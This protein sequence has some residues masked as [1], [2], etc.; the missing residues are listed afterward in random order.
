MRIIVVFIFLLFFSISSNAKSWEYD[1]RDALIEK[2][3][4]S[5]NKIHSLDMRIID[6]YINKIS[7]HAKQ[8]PP[9]FSSKEEQVEVIDKLQKLLSLLEIISESQHSN[10][11]FLVRAAFS[12]SMGHNVNLKGAAEKSK[13]YFE[14][15]LN[16]KPDDPVVNYQYGMFL[17]GTKKYHYDSIPFLEKALK[18]GYEGARYTLGLLYYQQ[19]NNEKGI[20]M[21][22]KY[23]SD[24]PDNDHAKKV[25][26]SI[27]TG[28]LRFESK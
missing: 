16:I 2:D 6:Y 11:E 12:N 20:I 19:G 21:L 25:I 14:L 13:I 7:R 18:L 23:S 4:G 28:K 15:L 17:L 22:K 1:L 9:R 8:Y 24:N 26:D 3:D 5:G 27:N 10:S